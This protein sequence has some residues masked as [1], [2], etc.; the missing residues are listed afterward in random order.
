MEIGADRELAEPLRAQVARE[1]EAAPDHLLDRLGTLAVEPARD[2]KQQL[3]VGLGDPDPALGVRLAVEHRPEVRVL[4]ARP[5]DELR[6]EMLRVA[7]C[8]G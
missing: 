4:Q 7:G 8:I 3:A 6:V 1:V 5:E 2:V